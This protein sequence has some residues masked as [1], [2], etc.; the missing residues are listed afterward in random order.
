MD[1]VLGFF[2]YGLILLHEL[3]TNDRSVY[4]FHEQLHLQSVASSHAGF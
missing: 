1:A 4:G 2:V 3:L